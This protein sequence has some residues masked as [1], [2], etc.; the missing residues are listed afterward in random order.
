MLYPPCTESFEQGCAL[1]DIS[2]SK[3]NQN[4]LPGGFFPV[5]GHRHS[6]R[7][8]SRCLS[9]VIDVHFFLSNLIEGIKGSD[10]KTAG[11]CCQVKKMDTSCA[12]HPNSLKNIQKC[13]APVY[14]FTPTQL[15]CPRPKSFRTFDSAEFTMS[16]T[17]V[18]VRISRVEWE[19]VSSSPAYGARWVAVL[20]LW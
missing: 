13:P 11:K 10:R 19:P 6:N 15:L 20:L 5:A 14:Q 4:P 16:S 17:S 18:S 8:R 2:F 9:S 1:C 3:T 7:S 12:N